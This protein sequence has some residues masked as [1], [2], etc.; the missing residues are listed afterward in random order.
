MLAP[1]LY[2]I[3]FLSLV[4][5]LSY[6]EYSRMVPG[7]TLP[8]TVLGAI[9][10][11]ACLPAAYWLGFDAMPAALALFLILSGFFCMLGTPA[12]AIEKSARMSFGYVYIGGSI[13]CLVAIMSLPQGRHW[14]LFILALVALVDIAGYFTGTLLGRHKLAPR[15]SPN[16]SWEGVAGGLLAAAGGGWISSLWLTLPEAPWWGMICLGVILGI[17]SMVGDLFESALKRISGVKDSGKLLPGHGGLLDRMDGYLLAI[18]AFLL[19][20]H[21]WQA[22]GAAD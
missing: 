16:K 18:P 7:L 14:L 9:F 5:G 6:I 8:E 10:C 2:I 3:L 17:S 19:A 13:S 22:L 1:P 15:I 4:A 12:L 11:I 20:L 21:I